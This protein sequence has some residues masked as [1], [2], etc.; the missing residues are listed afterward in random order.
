MDKPCEKS[1][2]NPVNFA[3]FSRVLTTQHREERVVYQGPNKLNLLPIKDIFYIP[4]SALLRSGPN[5]GDGS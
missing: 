3:L 5:D 2:K 1:K 4:S